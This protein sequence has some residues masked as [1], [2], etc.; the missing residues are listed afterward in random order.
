MRIRPFRPDDAER[1]ATIFYR[2]VR[3]AALKAYSEEQVAV[4]APKIP[5]AHIYRRRAVDD[6]VLLVA[7]DERDVPAAYADLESNGHIFHLYCIPEFI[8][9]GMVSKLYDALEIEARGRG[10]T[11]LYVEAS[12][13][14][15]PVFERKGFSLVRRNDFTHRKVKI[16]NY[17]MEKMLARISQ[18]ASIY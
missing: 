1:L 12:E 8:G 15:R 16:H 13:L 7:V 11:R 6:R 9:T 14:A 5:R 17:I 10:I 3:E 4:W 18:D 2:S